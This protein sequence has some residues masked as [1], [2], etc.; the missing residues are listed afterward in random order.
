MEELIEPSVLLAD[1]CRGRTYEGAL[2][3]EDAWPLTLVALKRGLRLL[4]LS[5]RHHLYC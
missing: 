5:G 1:S 3:P 2:S 4:L